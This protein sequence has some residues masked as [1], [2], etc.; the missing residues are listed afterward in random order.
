MFELYGVDK[1]TLPSYTDIWKS[2]IHQDDK[3]EVLQKLRSAISKQN[4][5]KHKFRII[6]PDNATVY[7]EAKGVII[8]DEDKQP[9]RLIGIDRDITKFVLHEKELVEAKNKAME[10]DRLKTAFLMNL[11]H[12]I[13]TPMN[14]ILGFLSILKEP[15]LKDEERASY[16]AIVNKSGERLLNTIHDIIEISKIEAGDI[17]VTYQTVDVIELMQ[18]SFNFFKMQ[19]D[20]RGLKLVVSHQINGKEFLIKSDKYK[21]ESILMN[22]LRNAIKFTSQGIVELGNYIENNRLYFYVRDTGIGIPQDKIGVIFDRFVQADISH[23]RNYEGSGVGLSIVKAYIEALKGNIHVES[24]VG[25]G[26][27]F[28]F[29]IPHVP[30]KEDSAGIEIS[31]TDK[32]NKKKATVL[33]AEDDV[34]NFEY[35]KTI[36]RKEFVVLHAWN[37]EEAVA[38]YMENPDVSLILMDI[39]MHGK[40]DGLEATRRIRQINQD[41][42]IIAQTAFAMEEDKLGVINAGCNDYIAKPYHA[43]QLRSLIRKYF[44]PS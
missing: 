38:L 23:S 4:E 35:L 10:S 26:S 1:E 18:H 27:I 25:K 42:T 28:T 15:D 40:Y 32:V 44:H 7:I 39:R 14:G 11:S 6:R 21:L 3:Q 41:V 20:E 9:V 12:E 5:F 36:L 22:L 13:R 34:F 19:A 31:G 8:R 24:E 16:T 37:G 17:T 43:N 30:V 29:N 33:I 2:R